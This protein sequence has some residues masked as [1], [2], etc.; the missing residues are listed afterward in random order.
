MD[1]QINRYVSKVKGKLAPDKQPLR[2]ELTHAS[3]QGG[4][5][6]SPHDEGT[7]L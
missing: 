7:W 3:L 4:D 1:H 2:N 6:L 5:P